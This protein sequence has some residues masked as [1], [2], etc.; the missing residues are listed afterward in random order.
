MKEIDIVDLEAGLDEEQIPYVHKAIKQMED[1]DTRVA[2]D[3]EVY[4]LPAVNGEVVANIISFCRNRAT[5]QQLE[6]I[7]DN[8]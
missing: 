4:Y 7:K 3:K 1:Y 8:I 5:K 6:F 2:R